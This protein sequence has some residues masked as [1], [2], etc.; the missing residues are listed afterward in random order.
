MYRVHAATVIVQVP[1]ILEEGEHNWSAFAPSIPGCVA[2][3]RDRTETLKSMAEAIS[4]HL[5]STHRDELKEYAHLNPELQQAAEAANATL[6]FAEAARLTGAN[7]TTINAAVRGGELA[8]VAAPEENGAGRRRIRRVYR[9]EAERWAAE[10]RGQA[11][12][13]PPDARSA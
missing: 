3:G 6:T 10:R 1:V 8:W 5:D 9:Q 7:L 13:N 12:Q 4:Y 11:R 2:T